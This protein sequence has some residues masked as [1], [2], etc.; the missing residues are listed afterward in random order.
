MVGIDPDAARVAQLRRS[1]D[2]LGWYGRR[3][4]LLAGNPEEME[5]PQ[6]IANH[7]EVRAPIAASATAQTNLWRV[8]RPY[9][10]SSLLDIGDQ[11]GTFATL[12][13]STQG[14]LGYTPAP[15]LIF[16]DAS[17]ADK[18]RVTTPADATPQVLTNGCEATLTVMGTDAGGAQ[19]LTYTWITMEDSPA[20]VTFAPNGVN[21]ATTTTATFS[22]AG[23]YTLRVI[24]RNPQNQIAYSDVVVEVKQS[25]TS[26]S[27]D[28]A[29]CV[30]V[31]RHQQQFSAMAL[32]QFGAL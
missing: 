22:R 25:L 31:S 24:L 9:S 12:P 3:I 16:A 2:D 1:L 23:H 19:N 29:E 18:P 7:V 15:E 27:I 20:D 6:Y 8:M 17:S 11:S 10:G 30:V 28:P 5:L 21:S 13:L 26:L 14:E 4:H 32:D